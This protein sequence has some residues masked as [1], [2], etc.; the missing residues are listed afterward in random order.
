LDTVDESEFKDLDSLTA[1]NGPGS[2]S[3]ATAGAQA[4]TGSGSNSYNTAQAQL[5]PMQSGQPISHIHGNKVLYSS[6]CELILP[7]VKILGRIFVTEF[8][9]I[10]QHDFTNAMVIEDLENHL[11]GVFEVKTGHDGN[12]TAISPRTSQLS[13]SMVGVKDIGYFNWTRTLFKQK[14]M[15]RV[16]RVK[17]L[18]AVYCRRYMLSWTAIELDFSKTGKN[19]FINL[20][21]DENKKLHQVLE[22]LHPPDFKPFSFCPA[23]QFYKRHVAEW[24]EKWRRREISNFDYLM[25]LNHAASRTVND[26]TQY[27][28]FPWILS[29]YHSEHLD[30]NDPKIYRDLTKPIGALEE[31]RLEKF[32]ER[33]ENFIDDTIPRFHYGS[34]YSSAGA[35]LFYL[36]RLE[37]FTTQFICLQGGKFDYPDRLFSSIAESWE[38]CLRSTTDVKELIPEFFYMP[39]FLMN[40]NELDLGQKTHS[41]QPINHVVLPPWA[42]NSPQEFIRIHREALESDYVSANLHHWIDLVFGY[43][44]RGR[45]AVAAFNTF[46]HVTYEGEIDLDALVSVEQRQAMLSQIENFGQ[47]P[48]QLLTTPHLQREPSLRERQIQSFPD[49]A[50]APRSA[51]PQI[52]SRTKQ[53]TSR[54]P[55]STPYSILILSRAFFMTINVY[56]E[57][58]VHRWEC[59]YQPP[60][61][62]NTQ[63][64]VSLSMELN[65][66]FSTNASPHSFPKDLSQSPSR[67]ALVEAFTTRFIPGNRRFFTQCLGSVF[68]EFNM[69]KFNFE[70]F[71]DDTNYILSAGHWDGS[72]RIA[73]IDDFVSQNLPVLQNRQS[74]QAHRGPVTCLAISAE[75]LVT[76]SADGT[77]KLWS[78]S[79][80]R[81][82]L[83]IRDPAV[84]SITGHAAP[85]TAVALNKSLEMIVTT[86]DNGILMIHHLDLK[87]NRT[88]KVLKHNGALS[89]LALSPNGFIVTYCHQ[90]RLLYCYSLNGDLLAEKNLFDGEETSNNS[91]SCILFSKNSRLLLCAEGSTIV[92]RST[93]SLDIIHILYADNSEAPIYNLK[94]S[95]DERSLFVAYKDG[96]LS[97]IALPDWNSDVDL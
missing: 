46:F 60:A 95:D 44:Q 19:Y 42:N 26:L 58:L 25:Y 31:S 51:F 14:F 81:K 86:S 23:P 67:S 38:N 39:E 7:E 9:I 90:P 63:H 41:N 54:L 64:D 20:P 66:T 45:E 1:A 69:A 53:L 92:V 57:Y 21:K 70:L 47:T 72:V 6:P 75:Y 3:S 40:Q 65:T 10:F 36:I 28:V 85:I 29:D 77:A 91:L 97:V 18:T 24:T 5:V 93:P 11:N 71:P 82:Q 89:K 62:M 78:L 48:A 55:F 16:W 34:H 52:M 12:A 4:S 96:A 30:L 49:L 73:L 83:R 79:Y 59:K 80:E 22:G 13:A 87:R 94:L 74:L 35:V 56:G 15:D 76:G 17:D 88:R 61:F 27:P 68:N 32:I 37:P 84:Y 33:Y 50:N 2:H 8:R 43:K